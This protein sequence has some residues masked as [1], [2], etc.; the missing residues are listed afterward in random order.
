MSR[1]LRTLADLLDSG[2]PAPHTLYIEGTVGSTANVETVA[3][4]LNERVEHRSND[5]WRT[6]QVQHYFGRTHADDVVA[7]R[8]WHGWNE[9]S[10]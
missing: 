4:T 9:P 10:S 8:L 6:D 3:A 2:M 1:A 7:L 5:N